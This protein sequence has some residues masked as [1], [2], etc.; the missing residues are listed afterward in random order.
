MMHASYSRRRALRAP[1]PTVA[2]Q[3]A[4]ATPAEPRA[5]RAVATAQ[6]ADGAGV[7]LARRAGS[8]NRVR[9]IVSLRFVDRVVYSG[10]L[11][12]VGV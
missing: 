11:L 12:V 1:V 8:G 10:A 7:P 9:L 4:R 6:V 2:A 3:A 5:T